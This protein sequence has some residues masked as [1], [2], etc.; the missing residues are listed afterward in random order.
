MFAP[1]QLVQGRGA[2]SGTAS[3]ERGLT[4]SGFETSDYTEAERDEA[5]QPSLMHYYTDA[6]L[7]SSSH[8]E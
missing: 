6:C 7:M 5:T 3:G 8:Y 2:G 4:R 1:D